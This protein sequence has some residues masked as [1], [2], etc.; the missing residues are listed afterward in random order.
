MLTNIHDNLFSIWSDDD[1]TYKSYEKSLSNLKYKE[2]KE[3]KK[4]AI[5]PFF[6]RMWLYEDHESRL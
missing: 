2:S 4:A 6:W 1:D 3:S 5:L